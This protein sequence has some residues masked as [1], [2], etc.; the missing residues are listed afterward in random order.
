M[1]LDGTSVKRSIKEHI[2]LTRVLNL[3]Q[4][5][6]IKKS[7]VWSLL[8]SWTSKF[9]IV[10][11]KSDQRQLLQWSSI[12]AESVKW[13]QVVSFCCVSNTGEPLGEIIFWKDSF[14]GHNSTV[15]SGTLLKI[16]P[17]WVISC[18]V[19]RLII[20]RIYMLSVTL[21]IESISLRVSCRFQLSLVVKWEIH[22]PKCSFAL[23]S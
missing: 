1:T 3:E 15:T 17:V 22:F 8:L 14:K 23:R 18:P 16:T 19:R 2:V 10:C 20:N 4:K 12:R 13:L 7:R 5:W 6:K 21:L 11:Y 9:N